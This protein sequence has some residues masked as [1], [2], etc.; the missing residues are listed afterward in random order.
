MT[1]LEHNLKQNTKQILTELG[2]PEQTHTRCL[3]IL[4]DY[5]KKKKMLTE[6]NSLS[7]AWL[8]QKVL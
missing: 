5:R 8:A 1:E 2:L 7:W 4:D 3:T 6:K